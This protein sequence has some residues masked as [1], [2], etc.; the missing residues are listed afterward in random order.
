MASL[1]SRL[2]SELVSVSRALKA[3]EALLAS[4]S[5]G[6][7]SAAK[8]ARERAA[9]AREGLAFWEKLTAEAE[10]GAGE[11][12]KDA[13]G[14]AQAV[15][16]APA[17]APTASAAATAAT[18]GNSFLFRT[19]LPFFFGQKSCPSRTLRR[20]ILF[21]DRLQIVDYVPNKDDAGVLLAHLRCSEAVWKG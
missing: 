15:H 11:G 17:A 20:A 12:A 14:A 10:A 18:A 16:A 4:G 7:E 1:K 19:D 2:E 21:D 9:C 3:A 5:G 8:L 13:A 6:G